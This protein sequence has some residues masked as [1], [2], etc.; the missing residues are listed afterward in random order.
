VTSR[1]SGIQPVRLML[2][3][4]VM[5]GRGIDQ[6]LPFPSNPALHEPYVESAIEYLAMAER[7]NGPIRKPVPFPYIWGDALAE[8]D[9]EGPAARIVNLETSITTR[10]EYEPKG[11]HYRMHPLN[12]P[13]LS[14]AKLDCCVLANNHVLDWGRGGLEDTLAA[15]RE[16]GI[17]TAG[18]GR[19]RA[20]AWAPAMIETQGGARVL[21][22]AAGAVDSGIG[23]DW[24]AGESKPGV[25]MLH[26]FSRATVECIGGLAKGVK[27]PGDIAVL[28][29]HWGGNWGY[30]IPREH[31]SFAHGAIDS[32]G[33]DVIHGHSSHH[34]KGIEV[35]HG[36]AILYGCGDFLND[37]EGIGG[38]EEFR[39]QIVPAYFLDIDPASGCLRNMNI[40]PFETKRFQLRRAAEQDVRFLSELLTRE[41]KPFGTWADGR[42]PGELTLGWKH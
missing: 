9:R 22:F 5:T 18:A 1:E 15:L 31:M 12:V 30:E 33:I 3:G 41:G 24:E 28:S 13:C 23:R 16:A 10:E 39:G 35:Y 37:Y 29:I 27:R 26:D 19:N 14:A 4:D 17:R 34:P 8:F 36:K 42:A 25:A 6:I 2:C 21:V 32:G 20:E 11:I 7:A 38:Y 40:V